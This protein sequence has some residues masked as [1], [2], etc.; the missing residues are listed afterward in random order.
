M[1][2]AHLAASN[3]YRGGHDT[4]HT[5]HVY[6]QADPHHVG[7]RVQAA[8]LVEVDLLHRRAVGVALSLRNQAVDRLR[9]GPYRLGQFQMAQQMADLPHSG[10]VV[11]SMV[12]V[13]LVVLMFM[14]MF[15]LV[16]V[17]VTL[18]MAVVMVMVMMVD[19][20]LRGYVAADLLLPVYRHRHMGAGDA[21]FDGRYGGHRHAGQAQ[22]VHLLQKGRL[23][24]HK[25]QQGRHE[26]IAGGPHAAVQIECSHFCFP[27]MWLIML[28][29]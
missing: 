7:H 27:P 19:V 11:M 26:H 5:Q 13:M 8:H 15:M 23:V 29:R 3:V 20:P 6:Q 1:G 2:A 18:L 21:A 14:A 24:V 4:L 22:A 12:V 16:A 9:V 17:L 28:A 25:L 10:V